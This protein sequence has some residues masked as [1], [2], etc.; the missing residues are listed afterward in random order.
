[1]PRA[2]GLLWWRRRAESRFGPLLIA[3]GL[4]AWVVYA[5]VRVFMQKWYWVEQYHYL[6]PF[7]SPCITDRCPPDAAEFGT[8]LPGAALAQKLAA[9]IT[10]WGVDRRAVPRLTV[11]PTDAAARKIGDSDR[12]RVFNDRGSLTLQARI[13]TGLREGVVRVP[14]VRWG[15]L[16]EDR[17]LGLVGTPF[18]EGSNPTYDYRFVSIEHVSGACQLFRRECFE[19]IGGYVPV[20]GGCIDHIAVISARMETAISGGVRLPM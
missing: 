13:T 19:Q 17:A 15:K 2:V 4:T 3:F 5:T 12:V 11:H 6:T 9:H 18:K 1:V 14:S 8:F 16:A 7:Y 10:A 20:K